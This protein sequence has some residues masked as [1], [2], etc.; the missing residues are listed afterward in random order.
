MVV[1]ALLVIFG[2]G[3]LLYKNIQ[4]H[5]KNSPE[6]IKRKQEESINAFYEP[7]NFFDKK[8]NTEL[9]SRLIEDGAKRFPNI[10]V[11]FKDKNIYLAVNS[12][13]EMIPFDEIIS[14]KLDQR[15]TD[16]TKHHGVTRAVVGGALAGG[17][18]AVVG[19]VTG[20][21]DYKVVNHLSVLINAKNGRQREI[22]FID[23]ET[24]T[25]S[26]KYTLL[27]KECDEL[28]GCLDEIESN[29]K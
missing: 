17:V 5:I 28:L 16:K 27:A 11:D 10:Y 29:N 3:F 12:E 18:G 14:H 13:I 9:K 20:G 26:K 6:E 2:V 23:K 22:K 19:A 21:K 25:D 1:I 7:V 24:K 15:G 4:N 8:K